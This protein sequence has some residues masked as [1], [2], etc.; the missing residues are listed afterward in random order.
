MKNYWVRFKMG[1]T[2]VSG[3]KLKPGDQISFSILGKKKTAT[4][5]KAFTYEN[6]MVYFTDNFGVVYEN[7]LQFLKY[8]HK[9]FLP[10]SQK[11]ESTVSV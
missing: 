4:I 11:A 3:R 2:E 9:R 7:E 10:P 6:R 8:T 5:T 1:G